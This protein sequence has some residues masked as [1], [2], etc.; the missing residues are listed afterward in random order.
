MDPSLTRR[1]Q[2]SAARKTVICLLLCFLAP[3]RWTTLL[4]VEVVCMGHGW[5]DGSNVYMHTGYAGSRSCL[6]RA[7]PS[8]QAGSVLP[9][10]DFLSSRCALSFFLSVALFRLRRLG[11]LPWYADAVDGR[12]RMQRHPKGGSESRDGSRH[13]FIRL[14]GRP[15]FHSAHPS[16]RPLLN[17][18]RRADGGLTDRRMDK[19]EPNR[20][21]AW[22]KT[23]VGLRV[24]SC[25][26]GP[27][28][29][30]PE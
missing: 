20:T 13:S 6:F 25:Y 19:A 9:G 17:G 5:V 11:R 24:A 23:D 26:P 28:P 29:H 1:G 10:S 27:W 16:A 22:L 7:A 30:R 18:D 15:P 3:R 14:P 4:G 8:N 12:A 21:V 2:D